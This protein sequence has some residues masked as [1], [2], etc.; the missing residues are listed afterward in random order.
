MTHR[1]TLLGHDGVAMPTEPRTGERAAA[2]PPGPGR[3]EARGAAD[4]LV[5]EGDL[6]EA[7][8]LLQGSYRTDPDPRTA[9]ELV[10][11]RAAAAAAGGFG[12]D[13]LA[14]W[15]PVLPDPFPGTPAGTLPEL[16]APDLSA[17]R[18]G[19]GVAHHGAVVVRDLLPADTVAG[20][21][22]LIGRIAAHVDAP[23]G[24][25]PTADG[26]YRAYRSPLL[27]DRVQRR[28]TEVKRRLIA[29]QGGTWLADSP[30]GTAMVLDALVASGVVDAIRDH[31]GERP[32]FSLQKSTLR[33]SPPEHRH[34]SWHQDGSF[35]GEGTR[36]INVWIAL[37]DCG[38]DRPTPGLEVVPARMEEV[39][40]TDGELGPVAIS[41]QTVRAATGGIAT[42]RPEF[43]AGDALVFDER[44]LHRT[45]FAPGMT[46]DRYAL[47]CWMF[48]VDHFP[49]TYLPLLV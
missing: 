22:G 9:V 16:A 10:D 41:A 48:A 37:S 2:L 28:A 1:G 30:V 7:V 13:P 20:L 25:G 26:C 4:R 38:G 12:S 27:G 31:L 34:A 40:P 21:V 35:L 19:G 32:C 8:D 39:L 46:T 18:L 36:T 43:A 47:E 33:R 11:L 42:C 5:A 24:G 49:P 6:L 17:A 3:A 14:T 23:E 45:H 44:F 29:G 15:P